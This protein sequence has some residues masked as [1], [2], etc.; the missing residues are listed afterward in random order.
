M[1]LNPKPVVDRAIS[2]HAQAADPHGDRAYADAGLAQKAPVSHTHTPVQVGIP[3]WTLADVGKVLSVVLGGGG[4][5][6]LAW[7]SL[8]TP[9]LTESGVPRLLENGT[10]R[11]QEK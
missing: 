1:Q 11:N 8:S 6:V 7:V 2:Q 3:A 4:T 9:R 10:P 5:P